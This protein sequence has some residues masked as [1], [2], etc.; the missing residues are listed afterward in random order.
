LISRLREIKC[1]GNVQFTRHI[2]NLN[3][4]SAR[5]PERKTPF[6]RPRR[7]WKDN[8]KL[9]MREVWGNLVNTEISL[10]FPSK[11]SNFSTTRAPKK[12]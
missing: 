5:N 1:V 6:S 3:E 10:L 7:R 12:F 9:D 2:I 8:V 11:A 4:I